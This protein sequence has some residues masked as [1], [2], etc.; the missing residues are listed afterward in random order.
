MLAYTH[1]SLGLAQNLSGLNE[2]VENLNIFMTCTEEWR[3]IDR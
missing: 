2:V 1:K 3:S